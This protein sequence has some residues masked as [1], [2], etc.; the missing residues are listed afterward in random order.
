MESIA[1]QRQKIMDA[2]ETLPQ[3][4]LAELVTFTEY[5]RFKATQASDNLPPLENQKSSVAIDKVNSSV[6]FLMSIAGIGKSSEGDVSE[7]DEEILANEIDPI[8]GWSV[9]SDD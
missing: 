8:S 5:L 1:T 3:S 4:A 9:R 6:S 7:R 2:V